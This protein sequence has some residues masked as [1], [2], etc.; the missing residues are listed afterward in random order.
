M[1]MPEI[2]VVIVGPKYEGNVGAIARSM[3]N[4]DM[5]ELYLVN[6]C[7]LGDDAYRRSKHG[8]DILDSAVMCTTLEE[9]TQ[10]CFLVVGTSGVV[11]KGDRNYTRVPM[12][13]REFAEHCMGYT[14][15]IAVVF[16]REDIGLLQ[17]ELNYCDVLITIP[18]SEEYPILNLSHATHTVLDE[19][20]TAMHT[21]PRRPEPADKR[22]KELMFAYFGDLLDAIDY[23]KER[24]PNTAVMFRRMMGRAIPTKYEYNTIMGIFGDASKYLKYGKPWKKDKSE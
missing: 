19:F 23:P 20:F 6:P 15:K 2:R 8:A 16:G 10:D 12:P 18:A 9:A 17:E 1:V 4:F 22:E 5:K 13:V 24:R 14:E 21:E 3:A 7:E 11:T